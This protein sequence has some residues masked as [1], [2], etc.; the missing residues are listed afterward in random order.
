MNKATHIT[1]SVGK[2]TYTKYVK[3]L[4]GGGLKYDFDE[5]MDTEIFIGFASYAELNG[6]DMDDYIRG[7]LNIEKS[8]D[9]LESYSRSYRH[10]DVEDTTEDP[11]I[12]D[13][14]TV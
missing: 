3:I 2:D 6:L 13:N 5:Y 12:Y 11:Y 10:K 1:V 9:G 14:I 8:G 7:E 4:L